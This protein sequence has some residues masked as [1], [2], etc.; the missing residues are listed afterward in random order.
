MLHAPQRQLA[1]ES[2]SKAATRHRN[3][4][5][6]LGAL[7]LKAASKQ[8][9]PAF[10]IVLTTGQVERLVEPQLA[11]GELAAAGFGPDRQ[12]RDPPSW[13]VSHAVA[14]PRSARWRERHA[15][16]RRPG[17]ERDAFTHAVAAT[18]F[19]DAAARHRGARS[20]GD[21]RDREVDVPRTRCRRSARGERRTI[22][23]FTRV[24]VRRSTS[25]TSS[26]PRPQRVRLFQ[27][28]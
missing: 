15:R 4:P 2:E 7:L 26:V 5:D 19:A 28:S 21:R 9:Q 8:Q 11:V 24:K 13:S 12:Q 1:P 25:F 14:S 3:E 27:M 17:R 6:V 18:I 23:L 20:G 10:E 22:A 16:S